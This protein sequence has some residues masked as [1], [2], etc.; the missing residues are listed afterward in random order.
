MQTLSS[1]MVI[2]SCNP[3]SENRDRY[4]RF[5]VIILEKIFFKTRFQGPMLCVKREKARFCV[6]TK[7]SPLIYVIK[8]SY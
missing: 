8:Q 3:Q 4:A 7:C 2:S 1:V 6:L 5:Q